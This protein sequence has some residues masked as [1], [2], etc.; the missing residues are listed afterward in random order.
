LC[1]D[2]IKSV[3]ARK[4]HAFLSNT[5]DPIETRSLLQQGAV[6][7]TRFACHILILSCRIATRISVS[8][9]RI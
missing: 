2:L 6:E 4:D 9:D 8:Y 7:Q 1:K 5:S 3:D